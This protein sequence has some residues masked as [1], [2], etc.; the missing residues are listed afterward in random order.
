MDGKGVTFV[1]ILI[2]YVEIMLLTMLRS[3]YMNFYDDLHGL[4]KNY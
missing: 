1:N 4:A 3:T 2:I